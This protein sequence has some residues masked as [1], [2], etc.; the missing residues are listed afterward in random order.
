MD[1]DWVSHLLALTDG[2]GLVSSGRRCIPSPFLQQPAQPCRQ[3][4]PSDADMPPS[5]P[6]SPCRPARPSPSISSPR[7]KFRS[8]QPHRPAREPL[9]QSQVSPPG[10]CH[11]ARFSPSNGGLDLGRWSE[12]EEHERL[13]LGWRSDVE[14]HAN[15]L[16]PLRRPLGWSRP[17]ARTIVCLVHRPI[18]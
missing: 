17:P 8:R 5:I 4:M 7:A 11:H 9:I 2:C 16:R 3:R 14:E 18:N 13:D 12:V 10:P 6:T 15:T 1:R